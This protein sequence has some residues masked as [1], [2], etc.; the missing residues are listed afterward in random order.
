MRRQSMAEENGMDQATENSNNSN[1][2]TPESG[3]ILNIMQL[4]SIDIN[5][6]FTRVKTDNGW[7]INILDTGKI[8]INFI[9]SMRKIESMLMSGDAIERDGDDIIIVRNQP[10]DVYR[11]KR[12][13][14]QLAITREDLLSAEPKAN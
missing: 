5:Q 11:S 3:I 4:Q 7:R 13:S 6:R 10:D 1:N 12:S 2:E 9:T 14:S 8:T